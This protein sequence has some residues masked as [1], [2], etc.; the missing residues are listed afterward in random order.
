MSLLCSSTL[1]ADE[2][3]PELPVRDGLEVWLD[4]AAIKAEPPQ[5]SETEGT[6]IAVWP[7]SSGHGRDVVQKEETAQPMLVTVGESQVVRFDGVDDFLRTTGIDRDVE[8]ATIFLVAA[9]QKNP[10]SFRGFLAANA[11]GGTD[12]QTGFTIDQ[13][14]GATLAFNQLNVEGAGFQGAQNLMRSVTPFSTLHVFEVTISPQ[15]KTISLVDDG[16]PAGTRPFEPKPISL[17]ELTVGARYYGFGNNV[18]QGWINGD[19]AE[20]LIYSRELS[21]DERGTVREYLAAK[22]ADLK[23]SLPGSIRHEGVPLEAVADP[24]PVQVFVPG[25]IAKELPVKLPNINNIR[26]RPDGKLVAPRVRRRR[27]SARRHRRRRPRR[28]GVE[29]LGQRGPHSLADRHGPHAA[30]LRARRRVCSSR[31]RASAF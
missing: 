12:F 27:L 26:Y 22:H 10:G 13:T 18:V 9:P 11:E 2:A 17:D 20:V 5:G 8:A 3:R 19:I 29:V 25:F 24:P 14:G 28:Q 16:E 15:K 1:A 7:D 21:D 23:V 4:A 30:R 31:R 6:P